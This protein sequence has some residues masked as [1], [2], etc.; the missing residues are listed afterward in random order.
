VLIFGVLAIVTSAGIGGLVGWQNRDA[1]VRVQLADHVWTGHL[2]EVLV[3]GA[4]L[5]CWLLLGA[6]CIHVRLRE[7]RERRATRAVTTATDVD[8]TSVTRRAPQRDR[9]G[10]RRRHVGAVG[11]PH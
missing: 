5:A 8:R 11:V 2:Y 3:F 1:I 4:L 7:R 9:S 6:S 10:R